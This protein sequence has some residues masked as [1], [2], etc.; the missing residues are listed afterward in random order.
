MVNELL[1]SIDKGA[2]YAFSEEI[3]KSSLLV[4]LLQAGDWVGSYIGV[5]LV[6]ALACALLLT[7]SRVRAAAVAAIAVALGALAVEGVHAAVP[8][9][10]PDN[11]ANLV[12]ATEMLHS[13]PAREV[14]T[15]TLAG[16]LLVFAAWGSLQSWPGRLT[17]T[18]VVIVLVLWVA[19]SQIML[20]LHFVTDVAAGLFGGLALALLVTRLIA[21]HPR[22]AGL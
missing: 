21:R 10:R 13:F 16:T 6:M 7:Q 5:V 15:F 14:F 1:K 3:K 9:P 8:V 12:N 20:V 22:P 2:Y 19:M 18:A 17:V 4:Q 11:A